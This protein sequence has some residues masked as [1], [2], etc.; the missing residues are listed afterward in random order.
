[1]VSFQNRTTAGLFE[2]IRKVF[3]Q[4]TW[5]IEL[6]RPEIH[7]ESLK[8]CGAAVYSELKFISK[9]SSSHH[10]SNVHQII[11]TPS[12]TVMHVGVYRTSSGGKAAG[13][14]EPPGAVSRA[15]ATGSSACSR[16]CCLGR[17]RHPVIPEVSA[18]R[19]RVFFCSVGFG[20]PAGT[21]GGCPFPAAQID[22]GCSHT[23]FIFRHWHSFV[24]F[25]AAKKRATVHWAAKPLPNLLKGNE[26]G[27]LTVAEHL[28][29][30]LWGQSI[31]LYYEYSEEPFDRA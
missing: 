12:L 7:P 22:S 27:V 23:L 14:E 15:G 28:P 11:V 31:F 18:R 6:E 25:L 19:R 17:G 5:M 20:L 8:A 24:H 16:V 1:M 26:Q 9:S 30:H 2:K 29:P 21:G 10:A 13:E 4:I 3:V